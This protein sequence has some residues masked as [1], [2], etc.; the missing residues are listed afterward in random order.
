MSR[1]PDPLEVARGV[2][3]VED[4]LLLELLRDLNQ[5]DDLSRARGREGFF[6]RLLGRVTGRAWTRDQ[7]IGASMAVLST[8]ARAMTRPVR[9]LA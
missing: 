1:V 6:T 8:Q 9:P 4:R 3:L 7:A 5:A 2:P